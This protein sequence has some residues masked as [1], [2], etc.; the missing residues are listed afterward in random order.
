M[1][2]FA[3]LG[4]AAWRSARLLAAAHRLTHAWREV[5]EPIALEGISV[6]AVAVTSPFPIVAV[7]GLRRPTLVIARSV[8][9]ACT[10]DELRAILAHEQG[11]IDRRDNLRR[12]M[13]AVSPDVLAW[14][15][16][17]DRLF[18]EWCDAAEE[19]A[20]DD[21]AQVGAAG[22]LHLASALVKV[23]R[24]ATGQPASDV[25]PASALYCGTNLNTRVRRL[26][27]PP[28]AAADDRPILSPMVAT[29][30]A[31]AVVAI[32]ALQGLYAAIEVAIRTLP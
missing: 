26:L 6:P 29:I 3:V 10:P 25:M 4:A 17:S 30:A 28:T 1:L 31:V 15:P 23:A 20:D 8:L 9:A 12:L 7:V 14:L 24:L 2:G 18:A 22:R 19:A 21:A 5:S 32:V 13:L 11:H 16:A 27:E